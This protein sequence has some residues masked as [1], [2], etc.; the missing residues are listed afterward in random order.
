MLVILS[1]SKTQEYPDT[2]DTE[3]S[4]KPLFENKRWDII[5]HI[6]SLSQSEQQ[7]MLKVSDNLFDTHKARL[8]DCKKTHTDT[9]SA[10]AIHTF[11]GHVYG[12]FE[13]EHFSQSQYHYMQQHVAILSGLYG[14]LRPLDLMQQYR[15]EMAS[16]IQVGETKSLYDLWS[17]DVTGYIAGG[18]YKAIVNCA[19][20]EYSKVIDREKIGALW[21]DIIFMEENNGE[22]KQVTVYTKQAR[23]DF[24]CWM[25]LEEVTE[26]E[27]LKKYNR[28]GYKY[29]ATMSDENTLTFIR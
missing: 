24:A 18:K 10:V 12:S 4:F 15:L 28:R 21:I 22:P 6:K 2:L 14:L 5:T 11:S 19:S 23:G 7:A 26:I 27:D 20:E 29:R 13:N 1:P 16:K 25:V 3:L 17:S 8:K 9:N